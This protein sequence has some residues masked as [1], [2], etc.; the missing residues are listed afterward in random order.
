MPVAVVGDKPI[1]EK[2][3]KSDLV[4]EKKVEKKDSLTNTKKKDKKKNNVKHNH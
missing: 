1:E 3:S 2:Q 4:T